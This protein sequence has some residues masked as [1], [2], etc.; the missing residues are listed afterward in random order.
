MF[1]LSLL[2]VILGAM[3]ISGGLGPVVKGNNRG[4]L[5]IRVAAV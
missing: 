4:A 3:L 1:K 2:R 5:R